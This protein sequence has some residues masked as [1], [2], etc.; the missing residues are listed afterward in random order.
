MWS[1]FKFTLGSLIGTALILAFVN[2]ICHPLDKEI[3]PTKPLEKPSKGTDWKT[4]QEVYEDE[5]HRVRD[6]KQR[7]T[8]IDVKE[9]DSRKPLRNLDSLNLNKKVRGVKRKVD[10]EDEVN[11]ARDLLY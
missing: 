9:L 10:I 7:N 5:N 4:G 3:P 1:I 8:F 6:P 2:I 11:Y